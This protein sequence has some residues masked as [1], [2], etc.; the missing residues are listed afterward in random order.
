MSAEPI[1]ATATAGVA[2]GTTGITFATMFPE[3]TPAV[4]LCSLAGAA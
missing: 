1:S 4:M 2:A 3:A